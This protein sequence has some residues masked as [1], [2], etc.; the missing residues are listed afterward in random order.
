MPYEISL[1]RDI[2]TGLDR[3]LI[4]PSEEFD[5]GDERELS[6]WLM[7]AAQNPTASFAIDLSHVGEP[8]EELRAA[9]AVVGAEHLAG[10]GHA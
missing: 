7:A 10:L 6:D 9:L 1:E 5:S 8:G 4:V 3:Y 2:D